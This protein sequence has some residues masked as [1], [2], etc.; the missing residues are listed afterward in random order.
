M[1]H[2][3]LLHCPHTEG[4][5]C[6]FVCSPRRMSQHLFPLGVLLSM[7]LVLH[8]QVCVLCACM[9]CSRLLVAW[10]DQLITL[11]SGGVVACASGHVSSSFSLLP[12]VC[13]ACAQ[14]VATALCS[15]ICWPSR[16][17]LHVSAVASCPLSRAFNAQH[18]VC[19]ANA[20]CM[21]TLCQ[22]FTMYVLV[23][24]SLGSNSALFFAWL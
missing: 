4:V 8:C 16:Q 22:A 19:I 1:R 3:V 2:G 7:L 12:G 23:Y 21:Q 11:H 24:H 20:T 6:L 9:L 10:L 5:C 15:L 17:C 13:F 14:L 18:S